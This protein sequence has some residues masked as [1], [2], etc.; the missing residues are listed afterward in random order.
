[1]YISDVRPEYES[2]YFAC[3]ENWNSQLKNVAHVKSEWYNEMFRKG[4]V[5]KLAIEDEEPVGMIEAMPIEHSYA[6]GDS[7]FIINCIWVHGYDGKGPGNRQG[8]GIGKALLQALED[9]VSNRGVNGLAAW[10]LSEP[11]WMSAAWFEK[12]GYTKVD[13]VGWMVLL[14]KSFT[15]NAM[16]PRWIKGSFEQRQ[17]PGK[18]A[19]TAFRSGQCCSENSVYERAARIA[20]EFP[21]DVIFEGID[22]RKPENRKSYGLCGGLY[23]NGK[24]IFSGPPPTDNDIR[25]TILELRGK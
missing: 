22:M 25:K 9:D 23:I 6:M 20:A 14:W 18:I 12:H 21:E 8:K 11:V 1:M 5:V 19:V 2:T 7:L 16:A 17:I 4:L 13:Q 10:G 3:L 15:T 24:N